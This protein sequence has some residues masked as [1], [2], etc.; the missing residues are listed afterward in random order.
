MTY[1]FIGNDDE[2][3]PDDVFDTSEA[4][5]LDVDPRVDIDKAR[6]D[7]E[8]I[9]NSFCDNSGKDD[10]QRIR[11]AVHQFEVTLK[12]SALAVP[13]HEQLAAIE[14]MTGRDFTTYTSAEFDDADFR[15]DY[16]VDGIL[17]AGQ[18]AVIAGPS[19]TL[20]T[21]LGLDLA[22]SLAHGSPFLGAYQVKESQRVLFLSAESGMASVRS[23]ARRICSTRQSNEWGSAGVA[24]RDLPIAFGGWVPLAKDKLQLAGL[25]AAIEKHKAT[26]VFIDPVYQVL[27]GEDQASVGKMGQQLAE[28]CKQ[29]AHF[30]ATPILIHHATK[31]SPRVLNRQPLEISD[32]TG[33]G[34]SEFFR[35]WILLNRREV[36]NPEMPNELWLSAGGSAGHATQQALTIDEQR[37][38]RGP[39]GW[40]VSLVQTHEAAQNAERRKAEAQAERKEQAT[41]QALERSCNAVKSAWT[42]RYGEWLTKKTI[43][44]LAGLSNDK[45]GA[46]LAYLVRIGEV[47]LKTEAVKF[48]TGVYDGYRLKV[49][50]KGDKGDK[51]GLSPLLSP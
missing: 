29:V 24:L 49:D 51:G 45:A 50:A 43:R 21:S 19:K 4:I 36:F 9:I 33:A 48:R 3:P 46:A 39:E 6:R 22:V 42:G 47:E 41:Q 35:Q 7:A 31:S 14:S 5:K 20:K 8:R 25:R 32:L 11:T 40:V 18:P 26:I 16:L 44:E 13:N 37:G 17:V 1:D 10:G 12:T 34:V 23:T 28:V 30:G 2:Y 15:V 27:D 38:E